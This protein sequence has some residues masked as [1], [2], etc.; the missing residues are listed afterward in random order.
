MDPLLRASGGK[1]ARSCLGWPGCPPIRRL[2]WPSGGGGL[3]GLTMSEEGGLEEVEESL[4]A[5]ASCWLNRVTT[6]LRA[7]S[8]ASRASTHACNRRQLGQPAVSSHAAA[9]CWLNRVTTS[10]RAA[11]SA[12]RASTRACNRRQLGQPAVSS[13]LMALDHTHPATWALHR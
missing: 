13:P 1:A 6:S 11:S 10:L 8:S 5:A 4:H 9:S 7:A 2:S 12:S 3:G